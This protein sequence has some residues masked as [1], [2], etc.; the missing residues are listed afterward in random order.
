VRQYSKPK[1]ILVESAD[2]IS[3]WEGSIPGQDTVS[4]RDPGV[5]S[6]EPS[7]EERSAGNPHATFCG[8]RGRATAS[9]DPVESRM[10][11][12]LDRDPIF[13]R[14]QLGE[15]V[16]ENKAAGVSALRRSGHPGTVRNGLNGQPLLS[17]E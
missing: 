17:R 3:Q 7:S 4:V 16:L 6:C 10:A 8:N 13:P 15:A 5:D 2:L 14:E 11:E 1:S 9:G 12:L